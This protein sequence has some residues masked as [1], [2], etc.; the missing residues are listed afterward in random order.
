MA[1][2]RLYRRL[3]MRDTSSRF[4]D[5]MAGENRV[6]GHVRQDGAW[7]AR[8]ARQPDAQSPAGGV[9]SS[10]RDMAAWLRL[11]LGRGSLDGAQIVQAAALDA[12]HTPQI[13]RAAPSKDPGV[14]RASF[15]GLGWNIDYD[16]QG[17]VHY[18]HSGAFNLG[19]A[20]C[21]NILPSERL[22]IIALT[23]GQPIGVPES[24]C[25]GFLDAVLAIPAERDWLTRYGELFARAMAPDYRMPPNATPPLSPPLPDAAYAGHYANEL[26]GPAEIAVSDGG[27]SLRCG[28]ISKGFPLRPFDRDTFAYQPE[29]EGAYGPSAVTFMVGATGV[30]TAMTVQFLDLDGQGTFSRSAV[31]G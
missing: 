3:G 1:A 23:N 7:A 5:F 12:T 17:R 9:T 22:G 26:F 4:A 18:S 28:S 11:Q 6:R 10:A 20:T 29:G 8:Y 14:E 30:A 24:I 21:V 15:Y 19:A 16:D 13:I 25:R 27:L 2:E 31:A